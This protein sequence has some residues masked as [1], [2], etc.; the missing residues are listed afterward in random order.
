MADPTDLGTAFVSSTGTEPPLVTAM[1]KILATFGSINSDPSAN[2]HFPS[3][4][5]DYP[6]P[7][8]DQSAEAYYNAIRNIQGSDAA[9]AFLKSIYK[10]SGY[11]QS[12]PI[13]GIPRDVQ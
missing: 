4:A 9:D 2:H 7:S 12:D 1:R 10:N 3:P 11:K 13:N 5:T 6:W 8:S